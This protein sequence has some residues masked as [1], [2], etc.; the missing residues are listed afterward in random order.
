MGRVRDPPG[1]RACERGRRGGCCQPASP[2]VAPSPG[3]GHPALL[4]MGADLCAALRTVHFPGSRRT[5]AWP[6]SRGQEEFEDG[7]A[8]AELVV[9][10]QPTLRVA[11][12][13]HGCHGCREGFQ[14]LDR[15]ASPA[16]QRLLISPRWLLASTR[17]QWSVPRMSVR[18]MASQVGGVPVR[19]QNRGQCPS[20]LPHSPGERNSMPSE[21]F[22]EL[23][24]SGWPTA[25]VR[26]ASSNQGPERDRPFGSSGPATPPTRLPDGVCH[27]RVESRRCQGLC[28]L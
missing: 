1:G 9:G 6:G 13:V 24:R 8:V 12:D 17:S 25:Y 3:E 19:G 21:L 4:G 28:S 27:G 2:H 20:T 15:A 26:T 5:G 14:D 10:L 22:V 16:L 18:A 7:Q 23:P 11:I